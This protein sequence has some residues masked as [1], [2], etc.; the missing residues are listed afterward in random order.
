LSEY[1]GESIAVG[2]LN[3]DGKLDAVVGV[4]CTDD[5]C[6]S[7]GVSVLLGNGDGTFQPGATYG[8]PMSSDGV[9][10]VGVVLAD[11][12]GDGKLDLL[13]SDALTNVG[14][15][16]GNGNGTFQPMIWFGTGV[17]S[18]LVAAVDVNGDGRPDLVV[19]YS[20][21]G[22]AEGAVGVMLNNTSAPPAAT[23]LSSNL[24]PALVHKVVTYTA[25]VAA[26]DGGPVT[27]SVTFEDGASTIATVPLTNNRAAYSTMYK[28]GGSHAITA[29]YSGDLQNLGSTSA[30]LMEYIESVVTKTVVTTSGSPSH[31]GQ[32]VTFTATIRPKQGAIPDG[33][34]VTFYDGKTLLG[35]GATTSGVATFTT[36]SLTAKTNMIKA[37]YPGDDTFEPS[38]GTVKQVVEK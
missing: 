22:S 38:A 1:L 15:M 4:A 3:G 26:Q 27:G 13:V 8:W 9:A 10:E 36:S 31:I 24:N 16:V 14:V 37:K 32:P 5:S 33:E 25:A 23:T 18:G 6:Q 29:I 7:T 19:G 21:Y 11:V 20:P 28:K 2:D 30:T 35:T 34:L 12:N 17:T